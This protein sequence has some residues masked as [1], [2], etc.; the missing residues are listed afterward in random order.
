VCRGAYALLETGEVLS[1]DD[2]WQGGFVVK[3]VAP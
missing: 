1:I 2:A 3:H